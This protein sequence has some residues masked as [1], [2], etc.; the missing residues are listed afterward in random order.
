M[1]D[2]RAENA[3]PAAPGDTA[4]LLALAGC[5]V[6]CGVVRLSASL[7]TDPCVA[8]DADE[9]TDETVCMPC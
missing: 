1:E 4:L 3:I 2:P 5:T 6:V 8:T 9:E 7:V